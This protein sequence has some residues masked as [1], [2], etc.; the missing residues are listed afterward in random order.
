MAFALFVIVHLATKLFTSLCHLSPSVT[1]LGLRNDRTETRTFLESPLLPDF[2]RSPVQVLVRRHSRRR[3][4]CL[5]RSTP[6]VSGSITQS[7]FGQAFQTKKPST[8]FQN[9]GAE[10]TFALLDRNGA[11]S[12]RSKISC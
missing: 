3:R 12:S 1:H 11:G 7:R 4:A 10:A 8:V 5:T 6:S 2:M 9:L